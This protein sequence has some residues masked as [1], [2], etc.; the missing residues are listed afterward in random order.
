MRRSCREFTLRMETLDARWK[1]PFTCVVAGPSGSGKLTFVRYLMLSQE[2]IID[3][4]F[5]YIYIFTGTDVS[6][7]KILSR[8][9]MNIPPSTTDVKIIEIM[10][11]FPTKKEMIVEFLTQLKQ[12]L[13]GHNR[14]SRKGCMIFDDLMKELGEM[15]ILLDL[16]TKMSS[17]YDMS[18]IHITQNLFLKGS[19]K[20]S[21]D[22]VGVYRNSHITVLFNNPLDNHPLWIVATRLMRKGSGTLSRMLEEIVEKHRYVVIHGGMDWPKKLRFMMDLF[23]KM[24]GVERQIV[25]EMMSD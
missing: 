4:Q 14:R 6:E 20:H 10:N 25:Y 7:N 13:V 24:G 3:V 18:V 21:S 9:L 2:K 1:H 15:G 12:M 11:I 8:L 19:G 23:G 17:H 22:H 16:F 5:Y